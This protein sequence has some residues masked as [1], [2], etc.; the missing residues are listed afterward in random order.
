MGVDTGRLTLLVFA[1]AGGTGALAGIVITPI[2]LAN[3]DAGLAYGIKG[4]IGAILGRMRSPLVAVIGGL[5]IG[6]IESL[7]AG[8]ISSGYKDAIVYGVLIAYLLVR[9]GV[10]LAGRRALAGASHEP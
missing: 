9:G 2:V 6:V 7:G 10:F 3:W 5:G 8:Y 4:F 1:V